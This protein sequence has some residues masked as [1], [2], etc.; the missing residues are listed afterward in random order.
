M[1]SILAW[2]DNF[3]LFVAVHVDGVLESVVCK[4]DSFGQVDVAIVQLDSA[5]E[6]P[7]K[8]DVEVIE[9][10]GK[11]FAFLEVDCK[12]KLQSNELVFAGRVELLVFESI[13]IVLD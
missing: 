13:L 2:L 11:Y 10:I 3:E 1:A 7:L 6:R 5:E 4:E 12:V 9:D 8:I